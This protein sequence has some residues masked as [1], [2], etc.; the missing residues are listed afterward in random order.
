MPTVSV[1]RVST[2]KAAE[3]TPALRDFSLDVVDRELLVLT[4]PAHCGHTQILRAIAGLDPIASGEITIAGKPIHTLPPHERDIAMLFHGD[5]LY[6]R[7]TVAE[8]LAFALKL[9]KF[10]ETE[11]KRRVAEAVSQLALEPL[12]N[13]K[14]ATLSTPERFRASLGRAIARQPK[15]FLFDDP[16]AH[17]DATTRLAM[18]AEILRL[19]LTLQAT[20]IFAT[21]HPVEALTMA[22]RV[23]VLS[24][25][26]LQQIGPP[27]EV[28]RNPANTFV[29]AT[30]GAP[31]MNLI[32]GKLRDTGDTLIFKE[33]GEGVLEFKFPATP[34]LKQ[35]ANRELL[36][37]IRAED[38]I[39]TDTPVKQGTQRFKALLDVVEFTGANTHAHIDTGAH[40]IIAHTA[41]TMGA[42]EAGH[43]VQFEISSVQLFDPETTNRIST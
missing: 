20:I 6:P 29:A 16:L 13:R 24:N 23:A 35:F 19:H 4:G 14:P 2:N 39:I 32:H 38:I 30:L 42:D 15:I 10:P 31:P 36:A 17:L 5:T 18:R 7:L 37:G 33:T 11:I 8:N 22:N 21:S 12:L 26:T 43:R 25:G 40:K 27:L 9:R 1:Q 34:D 41:G 3:T 28:Y